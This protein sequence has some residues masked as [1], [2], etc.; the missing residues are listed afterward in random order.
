MEWRVWPLVELELQEAELGVR[1][2][3]AWL[4]WILQEQELLLGR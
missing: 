2:Q 1:F 4:G 3:M